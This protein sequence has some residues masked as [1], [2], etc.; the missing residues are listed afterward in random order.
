M[1]HLTLSFGLALVTL[2]GC[3][4]DI[5]Q[6]GPGPELVPPVDVT[7]ED[8]RPP[9]IGTPA[10][11]L[12][13][14]EI[15]YAL[16][17]AF[18]GDASMFLELEGD[19][20]VGGFPTV[21]FQ[22]SSGALF[23]EGLV[24]YAEAFAEQ[25]VQSGELSL[26]CD[27]GTGDC[28]SE[29]LRGTAR[30][31]FRREPTTDELAAIDS[32][33]ARVAAELGP[34][35]GLIAAVTGLITSTSFLF[36]TPQEPVNGV[37]ARSAHEIAARLALV[38]WSS[39]PDEELLAAAE[40]DSLLEQPVQQLQ[41]ERMIRHERFERFS[42]RFVDSWLTLE[43]NTGV[44]PE[45]FGLDYE[46]W[47]VLL[48]D[49]KEETK[50]FVAHVLSED[51]PVTELFTANYTFVNQRLADHYELDVTIGEG[52]EMVTFDEGSDRQGLFTQ[53]AVL[54]QA[55]SGDVVSVVSRGSGILAGFLCQ[56][57]IDPPQEIREQIE[58]ILAENPTEREK[59]AQRAGNSR[60]AGCHIDMDP[61]GWA[62]S[63]FDGTGAPVLIDS[64]GLAP[65]PSGIFDRQEFTGAQEVVALL[66]ERDRYADCFTEKLL[67]HTYGR[68]V[69]PDAS[70]ED[71]CNVRGI[72][73]GA[74]AD[75]GSSI[76]QL[77]RR[78]ILSPAFAIE[79]PLPEPNATEPAEGGE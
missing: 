13:R 50:L 15:R 29:G 2:F 14:F 55:T 11:R 38:L 8:C 25:L 56:P 47:N 78:A 54:S 57:P 69:S 18:R 27:A 48:S 31:M 43:R 63:G 12:N 40:D 65:D 74:R 70:F 17:D 53:G 58:E 24:S 7:P 6:T 35:D 75:G 66:T 49:M 5:G 64:E 77:L 52:F 34:E 61:L 9:E 37:R 1:K 68:R 36:V 22:L 23:T 39:L 32:L 73:D 51:L 59:M 67:I 4:G 30:L 79:A 62:F 46:G 28:A 10:R 3:E 41:M 16:E 26:D 71:A 76:L 42:E 20:T 60:C 33:A 21:G 19:A 72:V 45:A 44:D